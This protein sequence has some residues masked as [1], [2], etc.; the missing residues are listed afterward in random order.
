M[1]RILHIVSP[2]IPY[3]ANEGRF[4]DIFYKIRALYKEGVSIHLHCFNEHQEEQPELNKFCST[5]QYY[6]VG[7]GHKGLSFSIPYSVASRYNEAL[8]ENLLKDDYPIL[9]EGVQAAYIT[10]DH[11]FRNRNIS[12]RI[13]QLEHEFLQQSAGVSGSILQK[14]MYHH[15]SCLFKTFEKSI[16]KNL[17]VFISNGM[18]NVKVVK[19]FNWSDPIHVP[20]FLPF[21]KVVSQEG[22]GSYCLYHGNL[23]MPANERAAFFL[24]EKVFKNSKIP[25]VVAGKDPSNKL[26]RAAKS[27]DFS[28]IVENPSEAELQ[29]MISRAQINIL[30]SFIESG[31]PI[32]LLN[33]LFNGRHCIVNDKM[34]KGTGLERVCHV[35]QNAQEF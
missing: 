9:L 32:K 11:R 13:T 8:M 30:P 14:F 12:L 33:S 3:P 23:K 5:V 34:V 31:T 10:K 20:L 4:L 18:D 24:L 25:F 26:I 6:P 17:K 27:S 15:Q 2:A 1:E 35:A 7:N 28:C 21:Q 19:D 22:S 29:D 16:P